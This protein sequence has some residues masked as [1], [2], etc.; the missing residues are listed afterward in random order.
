MPD[1]VRFLGLEGLN[2]AIELNPEREE[3]IR[4]DAAY[5]PYQHVIIDLMHRCRATRNIKR[6]TVR[7]D[8]VRSIDHL[9]MPSIRRMSLCHIRK[10]PPFPPNLHTL[11]LNRCSIDLAALEGLPLRRLALEHVHATGRLPDLPLTF[12]AC[13]ICEVPLERIHELNLTHLD[14]NVG[15]STYGRAPL[16]TLNGMAVDNL[17]IH[18]GLNDIGELDL[19]PIVLH[20]CSHDA[21]PYEAWDYLSQRPFDILRLTFIQA[22]GHPM[23]RLSEVVANTLLIS[24]PKGVQVDKPPGVHEMRYV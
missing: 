19:H 5:L 7:D 22:R 12:L 14:I 24:P 16:S 15:C 18:G 21:F 13:H 6:L 20:L 9:V 23:H 8:Y 17:T 1:V 3:S 2:L 4:S 10:I 11:R